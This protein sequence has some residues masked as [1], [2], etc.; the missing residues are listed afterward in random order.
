MAC[1][2]GLAAPRREGWRERLREV[3][4]HRHV[5]IACGIGLLAFILGVIGFEQKAGIDGQALPV[6]TA[7]YLVPVQ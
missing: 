2:Q 4:S 3:F 1:P 7:V 6:S 5:E